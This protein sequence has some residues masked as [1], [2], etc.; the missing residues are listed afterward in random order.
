MK[1]E[2]IIR[3]FAGLVVL[4]SVALSHYHSPQWL[5]VTAFVGF[6]LFQSALTNFCPLEIVL[7][8]AG[9]GCSGSGCSGV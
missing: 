9:V 3:I 7:K 6:N 4:G 8:K 2:R 1:I 5:W